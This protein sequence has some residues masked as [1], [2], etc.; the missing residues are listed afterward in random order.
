MAFTM[1]SIVVGCDCGIPAI[2]QDGA[3]IYFELAWEMVLEF[4]WDVNHF[5]WAIEGVTEVHDIV[6][7]ISLPQIFHQSVLG[8]RSQLNVSNTRPHGFEAMLAYLEDV[9]GL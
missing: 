6:H 3:H 8:G 1:V 5:L 7:C 2:D 9:N 4:V